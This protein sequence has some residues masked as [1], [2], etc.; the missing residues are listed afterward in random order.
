MLSGLAMEFSSG[1]GAKYTKSPEFH[2]QDQK[3]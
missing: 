3:K 2:P 1:V